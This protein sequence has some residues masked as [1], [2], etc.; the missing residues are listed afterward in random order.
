MATYNGFNGNMIYN[1]STVAQITRWS[2]N[3]GRDALED[4]AMQEVWRGHVGG[5]A[6]WTAEV[7]V[8]YEYLTGQKELA[9]DIV[10]ATPNVSA[11]T[12][13]LLMATGKYFSGTGVVTTFSVGVPVADKITAT[14][15]I[16]GDGVLSQTWA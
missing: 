7:E 12:L 13:T 11:V 15:S 6:G 10:A 16:Q 3:V 14:F 4:T 9:D 2:V 1:A 5:L 8:T